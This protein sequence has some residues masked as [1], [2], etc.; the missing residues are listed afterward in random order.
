MEYS[1]LGFCGLSASFVPSGSSA[2]VDQ[3]EDESEASVESAQKHFPSGAFSGI[4]PPLCAKASPAVY[5][6]LTERVA[7]H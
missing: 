4:R 5:H 3:R 1:S 2:K 7:S 6:G